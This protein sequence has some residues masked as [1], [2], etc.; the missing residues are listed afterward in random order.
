VIH[1][2]DHDLVTTRDGAR[3]RHARADGTLIKES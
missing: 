2:P 1:Y 3:R